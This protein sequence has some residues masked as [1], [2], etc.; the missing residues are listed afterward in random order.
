MRIDMPKADDVIVSATRKR[1]RL[2]AATHFL[3]IEQ[4]VLYRI[5]GVAGVY[6]LMDD[7]RIA[8]WGLTH[9][10]R[11]GHTIVERG[12]KM[13]GGLMLVPDE[14]VPT[15]VRTAAAR[16]RVELNGFFSDEQPWVLDAPTARSSD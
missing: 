8:S 12:N 2:T 7:G 10:D 5:N 11:E 16:M 3:G 9:R 13:V 1:V 6:Y 15:E 14:K 4:H